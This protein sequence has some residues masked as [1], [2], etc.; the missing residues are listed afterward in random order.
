MKQ[1][2]KSYSAKAYGLVAACNAYVNAAGYEVG[3]IDL[4]QYQRSVKLE[5]Y[6]N[7]VVFPAD[8]GILPVAVFSVGV[9][10]RAVVGIFACAML[11]GMRALMI[12]TEGRQK[13][14]KLPQVDLQENARN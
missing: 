9:T 2:L 6:R 7:K 14:R 13:L 10:Y 12:K 3:Q 5:K 4:A 8:L 11:R 1:L